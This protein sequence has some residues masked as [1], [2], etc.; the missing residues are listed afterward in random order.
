MLREDLQKVLDEYLI[1]KTENGKTSSSIAHYITNDIR[2]H[3]N[4]ILDSDK[5]AWGSSAGLG[6]MAE[7]PWIDFG[8]RTENNAEFKNINVAYFFKADMKG[9][10][11]TLRSFYYGELENKYQKQLP[12]Y[13]KSQA[14]HIRELIET[15]DFK[16]DDLNKHEID[17]ATNSTTAKRHNSGIIYSKYYESGNLPSEEELI[18][19]L[20]RFLELN[21]FVIKNYVDEM[22]LTVDE[23]IEALEDEELVNT[24]LL[25]ILEIIYDSKDHTACYDDISK[26]RQ[27]LGFPDE[28]DYGFDIGNNSKK[29]KEHFNKTS[30]YNKQRKEEQWSRIFY[31]KYMKN[32]EMKSGKAFYFTLREEVIEA[33]EKYD[34]TKRK[35]RIE[36]TMEHKTNEPLNYWLISA[37]YGAGWWEEFYKNNDIAIGFG[38]TGDLKQYANKEEIQQKLQEIYDDDST[39][40]N[41]ALACWQFVHEMQI[42]DIIIVKNG[43]SEIIGRGIIESDYKYDSA[44]PYQKFRKVNWTHRG[45]WKFD[46]KL[47]QKTL[48]NITYNPKLEKIKKLF[49]NKKYDS[50]YDYLLDKGYYFDKETIENYLLSLKVKPFVILTGKSG[51]GKTKLS[52]LFAQYLNQNDNYK[53]IPVGAN[54]TENRHILGYF[55]IIKNEPQYTPAYYLIEKS[56]SE[57]YPHFLILDE[58]NLSHVERYFADF[59]SAIESNESI[60][61]R[62]EEELEIPYNLFIIGTV[63]VDE[64]TYMFSPKVLD[65]ANTIE[66]ETYNAKNYMNNK[67]NLQKPKG[68]VNYLE[69]ILDN[70]NVSDM[71]I[72]ELK[73]FFA[74]DEFWEILSDEIF[75]F[76]E[77]LKS[78]GFDFGFR[79]INEIVRFMAVSY[80][81]ERE[82]ENWDNWQ[83]YFDAQIKQKMLPKL[84]GS[85]K[86]I[87][88]TL[89]ELLK[90]CE[91]YPSSKAKL[92]EMIDVLAK[93]RYVS[94]IN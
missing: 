54:W 76:Q 12:N 18:N 74:N 88:E 70:D 15:T 38:D 72:K 69:D 24:K 2:E 78:A 89:D 66:F 28:K 92:E 36:L 47:P 5:Y 82:P 80:K 50:F 84:H 31:G 48:T 53:I 25:N 64:T 43:M 7:I 46:E 41:D 52:Q 86:V 67:F 79:V 21:E 27:T 32:P 17:L 11:L 4:D 19:D 14:I 44:K 22:F 33:L 81:Y 93:Q 10:Y 61:L 9:V 62:G 35:D 49:E 56:Q 37:G 57:S 1:A 75:K 6:N 60:P 77:I 29:L 34:K 42:G 90:A 51:T 71:N 58:M 16:I 83:R 68:N 91:D 45:N 13:L 3:I 8:I 65:R 40:S 20:K 94:F 85:Q 73:E 23:W 63:N 39:H 87:G 26:V 55:N 59:L 30:L